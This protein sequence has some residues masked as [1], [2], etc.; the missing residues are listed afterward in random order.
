MRIGRT[1]SR[2][3][4]AVAAISVL[5]ISAG[6]PASAQSPSGGGESPAPAS[7]P[8]LL[9]PNIDLSQVGGPG[10]GQLNIINWIGYAESGANLP[11]YDWVDSIHPGDW[12]CGQFEGRRHVRPDGQRLAAGRR[13]PL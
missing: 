11:E 13:N 10:E 1:T 5:A 7:P 6:G 2:A 3:G 9:V 8:T 4:L 12:L